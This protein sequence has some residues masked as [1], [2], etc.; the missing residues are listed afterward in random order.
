M[1]FPKLC[2]ISM[3]N[4]VLYSHK[5]KTSLIYQLLFAPKNVVH[6]DKRLSVNLSVCL[7]P[8]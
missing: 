1:G 6:S 4:N 3:Y 7:R 5:A 2:Q 8:G